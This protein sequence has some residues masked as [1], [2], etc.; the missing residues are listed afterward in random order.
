MFARFD[1]HFDFLRRRDLHFVSD[2][3]DCLND[4]HHAFKGFRFLVIVK[5]FVVFRPFLHH[6]RVAFP[7]L[8]ILINLFGYE[9]NKRMHKFQN[10]VQNEIENGQRV[11]F[12]PFVVAVKHGFGRFDIPVAEVAPN[13]VVKFAGGKPDFVFV[14]VYRDFFH[15]VVEP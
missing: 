10:F 6:K 12:R 9:R 7:G 1:V 2:V 3:S 11:K 8:F 4:I 15:D 14:K 5:L 13:E